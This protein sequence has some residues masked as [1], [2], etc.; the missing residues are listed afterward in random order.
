MGRRKPCPNCGYL[1]PVKPRTLLPPCPVCGDV[2]H[3]ERLSKGRVACPVCRITHYPNEL[4]DGR[5][6]YSED[7]VVQLEDGTWVTRDV[8]LA[9]QT[10]T[11]GG[12]A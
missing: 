10:A 5:P 11:L 2:E 8:W 1:E 4:I 3:Q 12:G 9:G 7:V 6:A